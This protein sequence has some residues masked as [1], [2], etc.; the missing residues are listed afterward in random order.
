MITLT[1]LNGTPFLLNDDLI[2]TVE[3]RPDTTIHLTNGHLLIVKESGAELV[4]R[5]AAFR[6]G[7]IAGLDAG[8]WAGAGEG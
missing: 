1:K 4:S 6:R 5:I 7:I 3:E 2:E 8:A